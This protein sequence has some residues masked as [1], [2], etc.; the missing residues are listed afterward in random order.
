MR[1]STPTPPL[2]L[3]VGDRVAIERRIDKFEAFVIENMA[4]R[5]RV[6][7]DFFARKMPLLQGAGQRAERIAWLALGM[8]IAALVVDIAKLFA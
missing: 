3:S 6:A 1:D 4:E 5:Q 2:G 7:A 8:S